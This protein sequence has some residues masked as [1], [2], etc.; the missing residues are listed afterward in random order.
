VPGV[1]Q[2]TDGGLHWNPIDGGSVPGTL[3][4]TDHHAFAFLDSVVY[5]GND[6]G[7]YRFLPAENSWQSLNT[8][9][10]QT[11]LV[12]GIGLHPTN[13]EVVLVGLQDE[14]VALRSTDGTWRY[15]DGADNGPVAFDPDPN[16]SGLYAFSTQRSL[17]DFLRWSKD[18]GL[19]W[20]NRSPA[21]RPAIQDYARFAF[22]PKNSAHIV[23]GLGQVL[24]TK[25]RGDHWGPLGG[26][27][28]GSPTDI[29]F[30]TCLAFSADG[31][32]LYVAFENG[33]I[34]KWVNSA[35]KWLSLSRLPAGAGLPTAIVVN[36]ATPYDFYVSTDTGEIWVTPDQEGENWVDNAACL[37]KIGFNA[38]ALYRPD[39]TIDTFPLSLT[40]IPCGY[41]TNS[42]FAK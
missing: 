10:L 8:P 15:V 23:V 39:D 6:G 33:T 21:G 1:F 40:K 17:P 19:T 14:G 7:I 36:P 30:I 12:Q 13:Q 22:D 16:V 37:P 29:V 18:G 32:T 27:L 24:E 4:H 42:C 28:E 26:P 11:S 34:W 3:P 25:D 20:E 35:N 41:R 9:T 38:L 2:S 5:N 31:E